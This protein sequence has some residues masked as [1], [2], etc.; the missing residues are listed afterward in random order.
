MT[1]A[2]VT[3]VKPAD[4]IYTI[5]DSAIEVQV[6]N[7]KIGLCIV[8]NY[9]VHYQDDSGTSL[10]LKSITFDPT[11][12]I[13][14]I[15]STTATDLPLGSESYNINVLVEAQ[16]NTYLTASTNF[17]V[18]LI[19]PDSAAFVPYFSELGNSTATPPLSITMGIAEQNVTFNL[20]TLEYDG[21]NG[22]SYTVT[23]DNESVKFATVELDQENYTLKIDLSLLDTNTTIKSDVIYEVR[24]K[25]VI[26]IASNGSARTEAMSVR[27]KI[28]KAETE[29]VE[30]TSQNETTSS[31]AVAKASDADDLK[32]GTSTD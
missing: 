13:F 18:T 17:T 25:A 1:N 10:Q 11:T 26:S 7:F 4:Q 27:F 23:F 16:A 9:S 5:G 32:N 14:S 12:K 6:S 2:D 29:V 21:P 31:T 20:G 22:D 8:A 3:N 30:D 24:G 28:N 15:Y 19:N